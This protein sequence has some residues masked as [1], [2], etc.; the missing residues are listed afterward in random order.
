MVLLRNYL[1]MGYNCDAQTVS[2]NCSF[3]TLNIAH[4]YLQIWVE[5]YI[6]FHL[7]GLG[8]FSVDLWNITNYE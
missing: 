6:D 2:F 7:Q 1:I 4:T 5:Q 3:H 8:L